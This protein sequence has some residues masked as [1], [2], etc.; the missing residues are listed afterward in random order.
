MNKTLLLLTCS[1]LTIIT[2]RAQVY[3][4]GMYNNGS[5]VYDFSN[6]ETVTNDANGVGYVS[7]NNGG[8]YHWG[9]AAG[10]LTVDGLYNACDPSVSGFT[11][12]PLSPGI[13]Y[14]QGARSIIRSCL[15]ANTS[16]W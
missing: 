6:A 12:T 14:F 13:D 3:M 8:F 9:P 11:A 1:M 16:S 15:L 2:A 10:T 5:Q 4:S 7:N